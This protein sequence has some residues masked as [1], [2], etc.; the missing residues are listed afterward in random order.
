ML[1]V[2]APNHL[3]ISVN[4][5]R[6]MDTVRLTERI[7]ACV[8]SRFTTHAVRCDGQGGVCR[9]ESADN[10]VPGLNLVEGH[11]GSILVSELQGA[12]GV[13][14]RTLFVGVV[15]VTL[16]SNSQQVS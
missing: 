8:R 7:Q 13:N 10:P 3:D 6:H 1:V 2:W 16:G 9:N 4:A 14:G 5:R 11:Q 15:R 12:T